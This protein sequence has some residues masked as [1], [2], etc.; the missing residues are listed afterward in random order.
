MI[1]ANLF[2]VISLGNI[3]QK[4]YYLDKLVRIDNIKL[5]NLIVEYNQEQL[6]GSIID[7]DT[8]EIV[9]TVDLEYYEKPLTFDV[10][11]DQIILS[12]FFYQSKV[13]IYK[14]CDDYSE[15]YA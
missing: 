3:I 15:L 5:Q 11:M 13:T 10:D 4:C 7:S 12:D 1:E 6:K 2:E 14:E 9:S 8:D